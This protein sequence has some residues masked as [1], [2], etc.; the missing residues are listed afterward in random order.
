M[1]VDGSEAISTYLSN[2]SPLGS[3]ETDWLV[4]TMRPDGVLYFICVAPQSDYNSY[5][6]AFHNTISSIRF[7][8]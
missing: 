2:D 8:H 1:S 4:T 6:R 5:D 3:R 7:R